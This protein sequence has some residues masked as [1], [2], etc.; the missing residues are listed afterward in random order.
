VISGAGRGILVLGG[1]GTIV[2]YG[3]ISGGTGI[4]FCMTSNRANVMLYGSGTV[5][6]AGVI[7]ST[8]GA[9]GTALHFGAG[10]ERLIVAPGAS[11][12]GRVI[13]GSGPNTLELVWQAQLERSPDLAR[14]F[15]TSARSSSMPARRGAS[16]IPIP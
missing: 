12:V 6:N 5:F 3:T 8:S 9:S 16:A 15:R 7:A 14:A 1:T 11:F 10:D 13:G 2:N 4:G